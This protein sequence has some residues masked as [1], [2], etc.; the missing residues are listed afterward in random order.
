MHVN[1]SATCRWNNKLILGDNAGY[2]KTF[3]N[4]Y[5]DELGIINNEH[6][7]QDVDCY[8]ETVPF[9]FSQSSSLRSNI[10]KTTRNFVLNYIAPETSK[11]E[12][13]Y[14]TIDE[15]KVDSEEIYKIIDKSFDDTD[16][17]DFVY[18]PYGTKLEFDKSCSYTSS[19]DGYSGYLYGTQTDTIKTYF[20][21]YITNGTLYFGTFSIDITDSENYKVEMLKEIYNSNDGYKLNSM[22]IK[23][24]LDLL[25]SIS[26]VL[27]I[28]SPSI[29]ASKNNGI[30]IVNPTLNEMPQ[31][32]RVK[33]KARKVMFL[34]FY[35]ESKKYACEFD[36][37]FIDFR[38]AGK[39]RGE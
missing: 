33:E 18:L 36:R 10:A 19:G 38:N 25:H 35:V 29:T 39:Y 31:T 20:G 14:R 8:F 3:G 26:D 1:I 13:G 17:R 37:I 23:K 4:D 6:V 32:I 16:L 11:F 28:T 24:K 5:I 12:F 30:L 27:H 2:I 21:F 15:E 7:S 9:D 22:I 34:K